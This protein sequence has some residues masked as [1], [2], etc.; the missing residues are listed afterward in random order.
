[1]PKAVTTPH[2]TKKIRKKK[3]ML[4]RSPYADTF[5]YSIDTQAE[6]KKIDN[7]I[8]DR[9]TVVV[10]GL[11]VVGS[12]MVA[13]LTQARDAKDAIIYNVIGVD[14]SNERHYW[15]IARVNSGRAPVMSADKN[16]DAAYKDAYKNKNVLATHSE[17]AYSKADVVIVDINLDVKKKTPGNQFEHSFSYDDFKRA[18][19]TVA[20]NISENTLVIIETTVPPGTTQKIIYSIFVTAFKK[21]KFNINKLYLAYSYERVMAGTDYLNSIINFYRA[22][23]GINEVSKQKAREFFESFINTKKYQLCEIHSTTAA[24]MAKV[25]ENSYRAMNIAF[26]Q[27]WT[28]FAQEAGVNLFEVLEAIRKRPTHRNIMSPGFGV[29]GYCLP[30]DPLLADWSNTNLFKGKERLNMSLDAVATNDTMPEYTFKLLKQEVGN[31]RNKHITILGV[32]YLNDVADTRNSPS[33]LFYEKCLEEETRINL[34][35]SVVAFWEE[36]NIKID[37]NINQLRNKKHDVAVFAV[38]HNEY[39]NLTADDILSFLP[40]VKIIIDANNIIS[41]DAAKTLS[42]RGI[43]MI[44][45]GKGHWRNLTKR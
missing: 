15:K 12:A 27:E 43:K 9:K 2:L 26:M 18:L 19:E 17:Y 20:S 38:R 8:G 30:K 4:S 10:Q 34:H 31:L 35:D 22:Y 28:A 6:D 25:L 23:S 45:V 40:G 11:G 33:A 13:A 44:G 41:D 39:L 29:G 3:T 16:I 7:F 14:L 21:R 5:E 1:M 42:R 37:T 36:K 32:S 24:E